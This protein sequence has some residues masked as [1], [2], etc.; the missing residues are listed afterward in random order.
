MKLVRHGPHITTQDRELTV[1]RRNGGSR[2]RM[3]QEEEHIKHRKAAMRKKLKHQEELNHGMTTPGAGEKDSERTDVITQKPLNFHAEE[4]TRRKETDKWLDR[5]FGGSEWSLS[6]RSSNPSNPNEM[7]HTRSRFYR[8]HQG[9]EQSNNACEDFNAKVRRAQSFNCIPVSYNNPVSRVVKHTTTTYRP[10]MEGKVVY[11]S[12]TK[13]VVSPADPKIR[14]YHSTSNLNSRNT[15]LPSDN[16]Q[17]NGNYDPSFPGLGHSF[18][19]Q[20]PTMKSHSTSLLNG[21]VK[22]HSPIVGKKDHSIVR[23]IPIKTLNK[24]HASILDNDL[25][26]NQPYRPPR[27]MKGDGT[28]AQKNTFMKSTGDL[29]ATKGNTDANYYENR[30]SYYFGTSEDNLTTTHGY[31]TTNHTI[32]DQNNLG[33]QKYFQETEKRK[34]RKDQLIAEST[35]VKSYERV[36]SAPNPERQYRDASNVYTGVTQGGESITTG[37]ESTAGLLGVNG[38]VNDHYH[39]TTQTE[40]ARAHDDVTVPSRQIPIR[41]EVYHDNPRPERKAKRLVPTVEEGNGYKKERDQR[42]VYRSE[43]TRKPTK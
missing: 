32:M 29:Y 42:V 18:S 4:K 13:N 34:S 27:R 22:E 37:F 5:H 17:L 10:G 1:P 25:A 14:A 23:E 38:Q 21:I 33:N 8:H 35:P 43:S 28:D 3:L 30:R 39:L 7:A 9:N 40:N 16:Q 20:Q 36:Q 11:S 2:E 15:P 19:N 31:N 12:V 41:E 26:Q 6:Q 24:S